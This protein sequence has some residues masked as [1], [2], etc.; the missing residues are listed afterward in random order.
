MAF[1]E[2]N[3]LF[4]KAVYVAILFEEVPVE[5]GYFVVCKMV[6]AR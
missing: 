6:R 1:A 3:H 5:P 4:K 2:G